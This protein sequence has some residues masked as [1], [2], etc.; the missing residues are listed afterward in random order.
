MKNQTS[1]K[2]AQFI[3]VSL[4][5]VWACMLL[6]SCG[7][8]RNVGNNYSK[9]LSHKHTGSHYLNSNNKGCGWSNN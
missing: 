3:V 7:S 4:A 9:H 2:V 1:H 5:I 8:S 6:T